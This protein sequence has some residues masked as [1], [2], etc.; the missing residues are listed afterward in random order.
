MKTY[1]VTALN[2]SNCTA[3]AAD[4]IGKCSD[5]DTQNQQLLVISPPA[6]CVQV[7][8]IQPT[9]TTDVWH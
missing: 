9:V 8:C 6:Y 4:M 7:H 3:I 2:D 5:Y 1:T